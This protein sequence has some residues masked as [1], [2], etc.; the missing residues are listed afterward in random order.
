MRSNEP[1]VLPIGPGERYDVVVDFSAVPKGSRVVVTNSANSPYP[2]AAGPDAGL[3]DRLMAFDVKVPLSAT[4]KATVA[5]GTDLR[6]DAVANPDLGPVNVPSGTPV[7]RIMLFE[8]TDA[9]GRLQTMI[10]PIDKDPVSGQQ[11]TLTFKDPITEQPALGDTEVWEFYNT[12]VDA[13]PI[14]MHLVD[15]RVINREGF[16]AALARQDQ[17]RWL[18]WRHRDQP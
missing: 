4:P 16:T 1:N 5:L 9:L 17:H 7:R 2:N 3:N 8:G 18:A 14:H 15:F 13:H 10:G 6:R 11:G 12:T